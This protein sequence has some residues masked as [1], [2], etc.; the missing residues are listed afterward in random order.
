MQ[1][2]MDMRRRK[3]RLER[4]WPGMGAQ[5][6]RKRILVTDEGAALRAIAPMP[7]LKFRPARPTFYQPL[8]KIREG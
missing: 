3:L 2:N 4:W 8:L 7:V 1:F 6:G 5:R